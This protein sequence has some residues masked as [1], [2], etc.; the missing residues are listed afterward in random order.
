[1]RAA[2]CD[3]DLYNIIIIIIIRK[4]QAE[5]YIGTHNG[6]TF[7]EKNNNKL[8]LFSNADNLK[9]CHYRYTLLFYNGSEL[10]NYY[11]IYN[12]YNTAATT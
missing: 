2:P 9:L 1:M 12:Y 7:S 8:L 3:H 11:N 10:V 6:R 4:S 5:Y